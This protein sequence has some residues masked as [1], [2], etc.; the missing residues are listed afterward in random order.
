M[1]GFGERHA[2]ARA[3]FSEMT[4]DLTSRRPKTRRSNRNGDTPRGGT[5]VDYGLSET[6]RKRLARSLG[7]E[8]ATIG[9][10]PLLT[11][12]EALGVSLDAARDIVLAYAARGSAIE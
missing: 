10:V 11:L 1:R 12:A 7:R 5:S 4:S 9:W 2:K 8:Y 3:E 6:Q